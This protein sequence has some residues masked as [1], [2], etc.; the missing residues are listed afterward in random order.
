M[1]EEEEDEV[2]T[3][4]CTEEENCPIWSDW[5]EWSECDVT[6]GAGIQ[7][8][9]QT[10][11]DNEVEKT[12]H[13]LC[14]AKNACYD[15]CPHSEWEDVKEEEDC[16]AEF[17]LD[18]KGYYKC[19]APTLYPMCVGELGDDDKKCKKLFRKYG[20]FESKKRNARSMPV[21]SNKSEKSDKKGNGVCYKRCHDENV[22]TYDAMSKCIKGNKKAAK[23]NSKLIRKGAMPPFM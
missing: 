8:R 18:S 14:N 9:K 7:T 22:A 4:G 10:K 23:I 17:A 3:R 15:H 19:M 20:P 13:Q 5:S 12:E 2:E 21:K 16:L 11:S 1:M 6:C